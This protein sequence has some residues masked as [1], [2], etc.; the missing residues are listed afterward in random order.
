M[1]SLSLDVYHHPQTFSEEVVTLTL[2]IP[3]GCAQR[4]PC[5]Q[6]CPVTGHR[7]NQGA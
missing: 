6:M 3:K 2:C 7:P 1:V 4:R 5:S